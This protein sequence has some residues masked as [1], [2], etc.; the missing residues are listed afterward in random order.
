MVGNYLL[1]EA[2][3]K[4][5]EAFFCEVAKTG[6]FFFLFSAFSNVHRNNLKGLLEAH[7][8]VLKMNIWLLGSKI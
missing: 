3:S 4:L 1:Q 2:A 8:L 7:C 5:P 6:F